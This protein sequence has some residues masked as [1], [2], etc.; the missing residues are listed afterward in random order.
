LIVVTLVVLAVLAGPDPAPVA[1]PG[2]R[3]AEPTRGILAQHCGRCHLPNLKTSVPRAL[4]VFDLTDEPW[5]G[6]LKK[7][8]FDDL[9]GRLRATKELPTLDLAIVESFVRC[10]RDGDCP[11]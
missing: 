5:Y 9:L 8:Q 2:N 7:D 10:A 3:W 11:P 4:A 6:R 1:P